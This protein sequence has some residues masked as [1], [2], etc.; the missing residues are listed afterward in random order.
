M[1]IIAFLNQKVGGR[2]LKGVNEYIHAPDSTRGRPGIFRGVL[3]GQSAESM[4][5]IKNL[6]RK[7]GG[8]QYIHVVISPNECRVP[9]EEFR[10][11]VEEIT[12]WF[13]EYQVTAA[14]H[15]NT[16]HIHSHIVINSVNY[17]TG[18]KYQQSTK[19]MEKFKEHCR[20]V[21]AAHG[22]DEEL[23]IH[24]A[25]ALELEDA[26]LEEFDG[27]YEDEFDVD[28]FWEEITR[29]GGFFEGEETETEAE[30]RI[31][32]EIA[33]EV[34]FY[35][36]EEQSIPEELMELFAEYQ[37]CGF[38]QHL[39]TDEIGDILKCAQIISD[40]RFLSLRGFLTD[41]PEDISYPESYDADEAEYECYGPD[42]EWADALQ[43]VEE[44]DLDGF[45]E[46]DVY[47]IAQIKEAEE[48]EEYREGLEE[49]EEDNRF[50]DAMEAE[51]RKGFFQK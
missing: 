50:Y 13:S 49:W 37:Y 34:L 24:Q 31:A 8:R 20:R 14:V 29:K 36:E 35:I 38:E 44:D 9:P 15:T 47:E 23:E 51:E 11:A 33:S 18:K 12:A 21:L 22:I 39:S 10:R 3:P 17:K 5:I 7:P 1:C 28:D 6:H 48:H 40:R 25:D 27:V 2:S 32:G 43:N 4:E 26:I 46:S 42:D 19:D 30:L 45:F 41:Y 16:A